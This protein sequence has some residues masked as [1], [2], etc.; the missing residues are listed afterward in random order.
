MRGPNNEWWSAERKVV[1]GVVSRGLFTIYKILVGNS[2]SCRL[3][4]ATLRAEATF[5]RYEKCSFCSQGNHLPKISGMSRFIRLDSSYNVKLRKLARN[6]K[7]LV[8]DKRIF[9]RNV[10]TGKTGLLFPE[11]PFVPEIFQWDEP[12]KRLPFTSQQEFPVICGKW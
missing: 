6:L 8:N 1:T 4:F 10:P 12:K 3:P 7:K 2:R 11:I 5:S 9:I